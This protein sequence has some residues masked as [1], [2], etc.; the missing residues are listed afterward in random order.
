MKTTDYLVPALEHLAKYPVETLDVR[1]KEILK[2]EISRDLV[3]ERGYLAALD[4]QDD[5][6][7]SWAQDVVD[8][9][10][11]LDLLT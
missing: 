5:C 6:Y 2:S 9:S 1:T 3:R 8:L 11:A 10:N 4:P 7:A